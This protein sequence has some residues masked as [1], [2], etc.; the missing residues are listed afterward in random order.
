VRTRVLLLAALH[1][2]TVAVLLD[3]RT[4]ALAGVT[5]LALGA[6]FGLAGMAPLQV[7]VGRHAV[8][9]TLTEAVLVVAYLRLGVGGA[10]VAAV[11]GELAACLAHRQSPLKVTF[12]LSAAAGATALGAGVFAAVHDGA[13]ASS[14]VVWA[15]LGLAVATYAVVNHASTSVV[16]SVVEERPVRSVFGEA[17]VPALVA[18]VVS[19]SL[20]L[21]GE[22]LF[23]LE[24][25]APVLLAPIV[26]AALL[27]VR[28]V[29]QQ[30]SEHLRVVRL[31]DAAGRSARL[32]RFDDAV[33]SLAAESRHLVAGRLAV[34]A[35]PGDDGEW[36]GVLVDETGARPVDA[37]TVAELVATA[38]GHGA[39]EL[40][41][42]DLPWT[43]G[44]LSPTASSAVV[45]AAN[46]SD[47]SPAAVLAVFREIEPDGNGGA[48]A[49][50]LAAFAAQ[51]CLVTANA[52]LLGEV[53][54]AL[55]RQIDLTRQKGEFVAVVSHEL[56]TPLTVVL[57]A[58]GSL[59]RAGGSLSDDKR[60]ALVAMAEKQG[61]RLRRLIEDLLLVGSIEDRA[62]VGSQEATDLGALVVDLVDDVAPR[63]AVPVAIDLAVDLP[64]CRTDADRTRQ[65]VSNLVENASKYGG[66]SD[67]G[68]RL[69]QAGGRLSV[70]VID[71]GPG[72]PAA[73]RER[74][75]EQFVQLDSSAT[76][77]VGGTGLGLYVCRKLARSL[78]GTLELTETPGGGCTFTL[79]LPA[80]T[81]VDL[82]APLP[83]ARTSRQ[84]API[85]SE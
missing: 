22:L 81:A 79:E 76:R 14:P 74:V 41:T 57:G 83:P 15:R 18:S 38:T 29:A 77:S 63:L 23:E 24:P 47:G 72:I 69:G 28:A 71:H 35:A 62:I 45:A 64:L 46:G 3:G 4:P 78:E 84:L 73:D 68:V 42:T 27:A 80:A 9:V 20:G 1:L 6:A 52:R 48:R 8:T 34:C 17:L 30:R 13:T 59:R 56:R 53:E 66:G 16:L 39:M 19:L 21:V 2:G 10:T 36:H 43:L 26:A 67:I 85:G 70:A 11:L 65:I 50:V 61:T 25:T 33:A 54:A 75:F 40:R 32:Q 49:G 7:E 82:D 44:R 5:V 58:L 55:A 51:A 12:N 37:R 31:Y 60:E